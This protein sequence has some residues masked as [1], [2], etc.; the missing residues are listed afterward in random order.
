MSYSNELPGGKAGPVAASDRYLSL[1]TLRGV[2]VLGILVMNIYAFAMPMA[3]Y[4]NPTVMGG[5]DAINFGVWVVTHI[6]A[7][8]KFYSIFSMLF[9]AGV[10]LMMGRA[11]K[12]GV[13]LGPIY[14]RRNFWLLLMGLAHGYFIWFGDVLFYYAIVGMVVYLFRKMRP[15]RLILTSCLI[16][17]LPVLINF[18]SSY[19]VE[20]LFV[21]GPDLQHRSQAGEELTEEEAKKLQQ[22]SEMRSFLAPTDETIQEEIAAYSGSYAEA[23]AHRGTILGAIQIQ[24]L[25]TFVIWRFGGLMLL[26]MAL[27]KL[28]IISGER[29]TG[30]YRRLTFVGYG[31]GLPLATFSAADQFAHA[32]DPVY[33]LRYGNISNYVAAVFVAL[34]H[35]A[36]VNLIIKRGALRGIVSRFAAVGRMAL[37]NYLA[38]SVVMTLVFYGY[39]LGWYGDV[40]R[41][42]QQALVAA[43]IAAQLLVSPWWLNHFRFG[44]VEWAWRSLTYWERQPMRQ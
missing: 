32:F 20:K 25:P 31:V 30:F 39:G 22:W 28:G 36:L 42:G 10:I 11:E 17:V 6:L 33:Q 2:A 19:A 27:M 1:D 5:A 37:S 14:Y 21:E 23:F 3:A 15:N 26:G 35:L 43:M 38:H 8:Q 18:G 41:I 12:R 16:M 29:S 7:D 13:R 40:P 9:G 44:P 34:G 4:G 24:W